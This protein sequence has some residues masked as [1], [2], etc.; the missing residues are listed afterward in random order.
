MTLE[1]KNKHDRDKYISFVEEGH[2]YTIK[3]DKTYTSTTTWVK[4]FFEEFNSDEIIKKMMKSANWKNN[5][6]Y[7]KTTND[8]KNE[9]SNLG[10]EASELGT[11]LHQDIENFYNNLEVK[12]DSLEF[13]YFKNFH[14]DS[15]DLKPFRTE[16]YVW[17]EELK[18]CGSIDM[19]FQNDKG[20]LLIYDWK[21]CKEIKQTD[22]WG[23]KATEKIIDHIIDTNFWHYALQLNIYKAILEKNYGYKVPELFIV[24]LHP[25]NNNNNYQKYK[26]PDLQ[27]EVRKLFD[28]RIEEINSIEVEE[29]EKNGIIYLV[30]I[31][32]NIYSE[33]GEIVGIWTNV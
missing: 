31:N 13:S 7:G 8:I 9:W 21:R 16:W 27:D 24:C 2:L 33:E 18:L 23:K 26:I 17:D 29:M 3:G 1:E 12:N 25:N 19:I 4:T 10:K 20:D 28:D 32:N 14:K 11:K 22:N 15:S 5:K 30:D 6:Y